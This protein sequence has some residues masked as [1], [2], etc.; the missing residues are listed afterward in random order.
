MLIGMSHL[1]SWHAS[2]SV[3]S[4]QYVTFSVD[5]IFLYSSYK[6]VGCD[7]NVLFFS[8]SHNHHVFV[9]FLI[10]QVVSTPSGWSLVCGWSVSTPSST[11]ALIKWHVTWPTLQDSTSG[12]RRLWRKLL[13]ARRRSEMNLPEPLTHL[14]VRILSWIECSY[15]KCGSPLD[16][17][18]HHSS[19][20]GGVP[21]LCQKHH[22][23]KKKP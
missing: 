16:P 4:I 20:P 7:A 6:A 12:W 11:T 5:V 23:N 19:C 18:V 2:V 17:G 8:A 13:R 22:C 3:F 15:L 9:F 10:L 21:A 1:A 14:T